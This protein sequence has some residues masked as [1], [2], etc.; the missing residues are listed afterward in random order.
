MNANVET[1][2]TPMSPCTQP[3]PEQVTFEALAHWMAQGNN[4]IVEIQSIDMGY[5]LV[6]LHH[7]HGSSQL[8]DDEH[9]P[10]RFTGTQWISRLLAPLGLTHGLLTWP[11]ITDEMIGLPAE[12]SDPDDVLAHGTR[13]AFQTR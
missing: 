12:P 6:R 5:Y 9:H 3:L 1:S 4:P 8:V 7:A 13:V 10:R 2:T 11:E